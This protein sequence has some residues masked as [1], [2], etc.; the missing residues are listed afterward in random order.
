MRRIIKNPQSEVVRNSY[1]YPQDRDSI[2]EVMLNEQGNICAY[3][4]TYIGRFDQREIE[5]F[6]PTIKETVNDGYHNWYLV[7][8]KVNREKGNVT[9]WLKYQPIMSPTDFRLEE[10]ILYSNGD[11]ILADS[12]DLEAKNLIALLKLDDPDLAEERRRYINRTKSEI[13]TYGE[14]ATKF[15]ND[16]LSE[17]PQWVY[18]IR[19]LKEEFGFIHPNY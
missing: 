16:L 19:A 18:F 6:N 4:E 15:L 3:S 13:E 7:K 9:K 2:I 12:N 8:G 17:C 11:Y 5:H 10:R 14:T 1:T